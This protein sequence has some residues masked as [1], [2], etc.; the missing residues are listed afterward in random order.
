MTTTMT[1]RQI[2]KILGDFCN[3]DSDGKHFTQ[4]YSWDRLDILVSRGFVEIEPMVHESGAEYSEEYSTATV[5]PSGLD[6]WR[7]H[8][9]RPQTKDPA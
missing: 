9:R 4:K 1:D 8:K 6:F 2:A 7:K 5:S 3:K